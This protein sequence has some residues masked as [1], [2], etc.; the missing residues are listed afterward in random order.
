[1]A[2]IIHQLNT[3]NILS[4]VTAIICLITIIHNTKAFSKSTWSI[5]WITIIN[6]CSSVFYTQVRLQQ[7]AQLMG[8]FRTHY[9]Q[10]RSL[11]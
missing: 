4:V 11:M 2:E 10:F 9:R 5:N 8:K 1:M 7:L 3:V 6:Y